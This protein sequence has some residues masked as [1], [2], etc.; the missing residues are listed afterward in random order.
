MNRPLKIAPSLLSA[1]FACLGQEIEALEKAGADML[2]LDV[3]DGH[4][5]P[6]ITLGPP[7]IRALR[8]LTS[9]PFDVHLMIQPADPYIEAFL[10]AGATILTLHTDAGPH[11]QRS[12]HKIRSLGGGAGVALN[13]ATPLEDIR[14]I[15]GEV[16]L[17]LV[18]AVNPGFGGQH[19]LPQTLKK[20]AALQKMIAE[21]GAAEG[22]ATPLEI[23]VDGGVT[24]ENA[25]ALKAAGATVLV[26]GTSVFKTPDYRANIEALR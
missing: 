22:R 9:L 3:M 10:E 16:D 18:M 4:Y 12:L 21:E 23:Q 1:N 24:P 15:L 17:I 8:P 26:A 19:F 20:L 13:P 14:W 2:H 25:P 7:V 5:V 11:L 6:N